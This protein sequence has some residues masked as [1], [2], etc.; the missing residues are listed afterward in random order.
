MQRLS[1]A[2]RLVSGLADENERSGP[3]ERGGPPGAPG[4]PRDS[5]TAAPCNTGWATTVVDLRDLGLRLI[6]IASKRVRPGPESCSWWGGN[7]MLASAF[8]GYASPFS[9]RL[10]QARAP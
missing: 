10:R 8:V 9:A 4:V 5:P 2:E 1:T 7:C 3:R 6:G